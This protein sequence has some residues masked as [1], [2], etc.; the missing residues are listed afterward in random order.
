MDS[1]AAAS[2]TIA[3]VVALLGLAFYL[4]CRAV[5]E[6]LDRKRLD[7]AHDDEH[8]VGPDALRLLEDLDAH[9][10]EYLAADPEL[11]AGFDRLREAIR[12]E[13]T[14]GDL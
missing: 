12:D 1:P 5:D 13:Q 6:H 8:D 3:I 11:T 14:K 10:D 7:A 2:L 4:V 9:L